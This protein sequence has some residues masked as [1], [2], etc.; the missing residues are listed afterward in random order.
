MTNT[1]LEDWFTFA[2]EME[3]DTAEDTARDVLCNN[4]V[5]VW[6][7]GRSGGWAVVDGLPDIDDWDAIMLARWRRFERIARL[8]ADDV[9]YQMASMIY[10]N[11]FDNP[12][13][14]GC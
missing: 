7:E 4:R 3:W 1:E 8:T 5:K 13:R 6:S 11:V 12:N 14:Y 10:L 9:P 2:C